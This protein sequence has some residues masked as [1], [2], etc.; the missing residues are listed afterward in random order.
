M[1]TGIK[2]KCINGVIDVIASIGEVALGL[3]FPE[4]AITFAGIIALIKLILDKRR[5]EN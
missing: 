4:N 5:V 1:K 3:F 2:F